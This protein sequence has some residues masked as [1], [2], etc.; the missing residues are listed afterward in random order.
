MEPGPFKK[1]TGAENNIVPIHH[2]AELISHQEKLTRLRELIHHQYAAEIVPGV[3]PA[4]GI[5][6]VETED[7][8]DNKM[9]KYFLTISFISVLMITL[10]GCYTVAWDP[11]ESNF[12]TRDNSFQSSNNLNTQSGYNYY[13][14]SPWWWKI[15]P[16]I[17]ED[18]TDYADEDFG[19]GTIIID[20][21]AVIP[22]IIPS[23]PAAQI[24][25]RSPGNRS[26]PLVRPNKDKSQDTRSRDNSTNNTN[27]TR[28]D[29][30]S[31]NTDT[32]RKR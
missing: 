30:G 19:S 3:Q 21:G 13:D 23:V 16:R 8:G 6:P 32:G 17:F 4:E 20:N 11:G 26:L 25:V 7:A 18:A 29:N 2:Q 9:K 28:N 22:I 5:I 1:I 10:T 15:D 12:P 24:I 14:N 27:K 31:R